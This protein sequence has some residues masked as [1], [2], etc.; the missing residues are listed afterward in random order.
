L[1]VSDLAPYVSSDPEVWFR[2][3]HLGFE[4][5]SACQGPHG[6]L[7]RYDTRIIDNQQMVVA[8]DS[9]YVVSTGLTKISILLFYRRMAA[10]TVSIGFLRAVHAAIGFVIAY[11][12]TFQFTIWFG[13]RPTNALWN[14]VDPSWAFEHEGQYSCTSELA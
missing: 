4:D 7:L 5:P 13:C 10:G 14:Q 11:M 8:T 12:I 9:L 1:H 3:P 6:M 2:H